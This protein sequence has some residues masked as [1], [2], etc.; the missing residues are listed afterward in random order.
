[1]CDERKLEIVVE[2]A[3]SLHDKSFEHG[4]YHV[5]RVYKWSIKIIENQN[6]NINP[7]HLRI[8]T[9]LHDVGR[10]IGEPHAYYSALITEILLREAECDNSVIE[11]ITTAIKA[12]SFSYSRNIK[13]A[14]ELGKI[15]SDADKLDA[16]GLI[17]FLRVFLYSERN[18]RD[19]E[20]TIRHFHDKI[21][22]LHMLMNYEYSRK[23]AEKLTEKVIVLLNNLKEELGEI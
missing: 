18:N 4:V 14:N 10:I 1:M 8:A 20:A 17:G 5:E 11:E 3:R 12:H 6:I 13:Y 9:Y 16:L 21:L 19:L 23:I 15:L 2:I 22:K 7:V